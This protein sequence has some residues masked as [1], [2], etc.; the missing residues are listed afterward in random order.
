[1]LDASV[2]LYLF[3]KYRIHRRGFLKSLVAYQIFFLASFLLLFIHAYFVVNVS[4]NFLEQNIPYYDIIEA[5][6]KCVLIAG[7]SFS[8]VSIT[9]VFW[10]KEEQNQ[11]VW[12][13]GLFT[14]AGLSVGY[15][16]KM[17]VGEGPYF[18]WLD[19]LNDYFFENI[20]IIEPI[21]LVGF[22]VRANCLP[23]NRL[24]PSVRA[25]GA[26]FLTAL[27]PCC[28]LRPDLRSC[29]REPPDAIC[30]CF[31]SLFIDQHCACGVAEILL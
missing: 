21:L 31:S 6:I 26:L 15:I 17:I 19:F 4:E 27:C 18:F 10:G 12:P 22:I 1:M 25:F 9:L 5:L 14:I 16:G 3:L 11:A 23:E 29:W 8:I 30:H 28:T 13:W 20:I 24:A 2:V 7:I